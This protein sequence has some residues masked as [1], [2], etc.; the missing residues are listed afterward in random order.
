LGKVKSNGEKDTTK[1]KKNF[2]LMVYGFVVAV[3]RV[4]A[5]RG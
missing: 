2:R 4:V 5:E 1:I 3:V